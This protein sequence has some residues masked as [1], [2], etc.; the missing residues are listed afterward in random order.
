M[1]TIVKKL[2]FVG[3]LSFVLVA[4][5]KEDIMSNDVTGESSTQEMSKLNHEQVLTQKPAL[6]VNAVSGI[7]FDKFKGYT[8]IN[9]N[10][11]GRYQT[12]I[13]AKTCL[14]IKFTDNVRTSYNVYHV[15]LK[16][17]GN[18]GKIYLQRYREHIFDHKY[19]DDDINEDNPSTSYDDFV[20][21]EVSPGSVRETNSFGSQF[22]NGWNVQSH[23]W[24]RFYNPNSHAVGCVVNI[25]L[26]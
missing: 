17:T 2:L 9:A 8:E 1:K 23:Q 7:S 13:P 5:N 14:Y 3:V 18:S 12:Y 21:H 24:I 6:V 11:A 15:W 20:N 4:C 10:T 22:D 25:Q 26:H 19:D 16:N